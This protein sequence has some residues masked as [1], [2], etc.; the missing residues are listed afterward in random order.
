[1]LRL[2]DFEA[3]ALEQRLGGTLLAEPLALEHELRKTAPDE[4]ARRGES[5]LPQTHT[6][7]CS[8]R[9]APRPLPARLDSRGH[10]FEGCGFTPTRRQLVE[11]AGAFA[12]SGGAR[13]RICYAA[14]VAG[15]GSRPWSWAHRLA[16]VRL[17]TS[18]L[19]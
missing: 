2:H 12:W 11:A 19:R 4:L 17:A 13:S 10:P 7:Q 16:S 9:N 18:S 3:V 6:S 15:S 5:S 1:M 14:S 8:A